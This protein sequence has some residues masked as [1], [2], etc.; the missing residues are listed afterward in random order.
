MK[1]SVKITGPKRCPLG[2]FVNRDARSARITSRS[3]TVEE[4]L[5]SGPPSE[6][7][8]T[9]LSE[10]FRSD[11]GHVYRFSRPNG[12]LC[13]S[14]ADIGIPVTESRFKDGCLRLQFH[15]EDTN[16]LKAAVQTLREQAKSVTVSQLVHGDTELDSTRPI[17]VDLSSLTDRQAEILQRAYQGGYFNHPRKMSVNDL[18]EEFDLA[19]STVTQHLYAGMGKVFEQ[20]M[21]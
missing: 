7:S 2:E 21:E 14:L 5:L 9:T 17:T 18:A 19:P 20:L 11:D 3:E 13:D 8:D 12:C 10:Q 1:V 15:A 4:V 16:E 6:R